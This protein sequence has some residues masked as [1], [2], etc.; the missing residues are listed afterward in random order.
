MAREKKQGVITIRVSDDYKN[1]LKQKAKDV[2]MDLSKYVINCI[3]SNRTNV[4]HDGDILIAEIYN[5]NEQLQKLT[6]YKSLPIQELQNSLSNAI[7]KLN[8]LANK[9]D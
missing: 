1:N 8:T 3:N 2:G 5:L 7:S 6:L 9:D 4:I